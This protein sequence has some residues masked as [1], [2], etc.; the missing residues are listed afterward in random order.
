MSNNIHL[1]NA[2]G[3]VIGGIG[4]PDKGLFKAATR[5]ELLRNEAGIG[6]GGPAARRFGM[7]TKKSCH[8]RRRAVS[9]QFTFETFH[10]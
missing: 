7:A 4:Q 1:A 9:R 8:F 10:L 6:A 3:R 2:K 5:A